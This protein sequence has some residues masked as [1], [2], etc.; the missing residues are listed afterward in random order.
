[1][2]AF[3]ISS[4]QNTTVTGDKTA[5]IAST[6]TSTITQA[7]TTATTDLNSIVSVI[8]P[9]T[10]LDEK[11]IQDA[12]NQNI[13][14]FPVNISE[15]GTASYATIPNNGGVIYATVPNNGGVIYLLGKQSIE[16]STTATNNTTFAVKSLTEANPETN[17]SPDSNNQAIQ[18]AE[19]PPIDMNQLPPPIDINELSK[20]P[21]PEDIKQALEIKDTSPS[22]IPSGLTSQ[23]PPPPRKEMRQKQLDMMLGN[24]WGNKRL[25]PPKREFEI[26][27]NEDKTSAEVLIKTDFIKE[28]SFNE[29]NMVLE[30]KNFQEEMKV[31]A[32]FVKQNGQWELN[33]IAPTSG[34]I[35]NKPPKFQIE[36]VNLLATS[37]DNKTKSIDIKLNEVQNTNEV[38]SISENDILTLQVKIK[39]DDSNSLPHVFAKITSSN[40]RVPLFDDGSL[41]DISSTISGEQKSGDLVENDNIYTANMILGKQ[42]KMAYLTIYCSSDGG[43][44]SLA[45]LAAYNHINYSIPINVL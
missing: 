12:V 23:P 44:E 20:L 8:N 3:V 5:V 19:L 1:M 2:L 37:T 14:F 18:I 31:Q 4:C 22:G 26:K 43:F 29:N 25:E 13:D 16:L 28:L 24:K 6:V 15:N 27:F 7:V 39:N 33:K 38:L 21:I 35:P 45:D 34:F 17:P 11:A 36:S 30:N 42:E 32:V 9:A 10:D 41:D 40:L